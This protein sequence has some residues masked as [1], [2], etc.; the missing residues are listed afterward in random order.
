MTATRSLSLT[1]LVSIQS[2]SALLVLLVFIEPTWANEKINIQLPRTKISAKEL[3]VIYLQGNS[4]SEEIA[5]YYQTQRNIPAE[6]ILPIKL[7]SSDTRVTPKK[8]IPLKN[9]LDQSLPQHIQALA[10]A[11]AQPYTVGCMSISSA[12][13]YGYDEK[14]CS[15]ECATTQ[16]SQ[17]HNSKTTR[18]YQM[19][20]IRPTMLLAAK[21]FEDAKSLI[22]RGVVADYSKPYGKAYLLNTNDYNR[23]VRYIF[24]DE[25]KKRFATKFD[26]QILDQN[27]IKNQKDILF[28]FTGLPSVPDIDTLT[29]LPGAV[30]DHLTSAGGQ[31]TDSS[32][33]SAMKWLEAGATGSYGS[34]IEPC[35]Y[36]QKFPNPIILMTNYTQGS[37]LIEA[38]WKSVLMP[39]QG[40]FIGEPLAAPFT[41]YELVN[42]DEYIELHSPIFYRGD[43]ILVSKIDSNIIE[44][45]QTISKQNTYLKI[46]PPYQ[47]HYEVIRVK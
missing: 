7:D 6:N 22:D 21:N 11:W 26:V 29:Y 27:S 9:K 47:S 46:Y 42:N 20:G 31:L 40:N 30:A 5:R 18:P 45:V 37:T 8:F 33:M 2:I 14:Y 13:A 36:T 19:Y 10:L 38:Y 15:K 3:A 23:S 39:G 41:G 35:N 28:Y 4:E 17:Y 1:R 25:V 16:P 12:F 34:A 43:Y 24:F 32:Q 44:S